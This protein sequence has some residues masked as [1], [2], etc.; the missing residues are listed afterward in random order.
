[1]ADTHNEAEVKTDYPIDNGVGD[2]L[3]LLPEGFNGVTS[4]VR[5]SEREGF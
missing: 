5:S 3:N 2:V 4:T 1:M